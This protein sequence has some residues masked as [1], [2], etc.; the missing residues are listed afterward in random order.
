MH[1]EAQTTS[2]YLIIIKIQKKL[3]NRLESVSNIQIFTQLW[4]EGQK[5]SV[6]GASSS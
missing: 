6:I 2:M 3:G 1:W 4:R 5:K